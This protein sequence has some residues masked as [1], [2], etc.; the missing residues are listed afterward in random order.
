MNPLQ[1]PVRTLPGARPAGPHLPAATLRRHLDGAD[2][3]ATAH[4]AA[5]QL[6]LE[7]EA[8]LA[9]AQREAEAIHTQALHE[10]AEER[11]TLGQQ[12]RDQAVADSLQWLCEEQQLE[13]E[14][15]RQLAQ[16]W[17]SLT[18]NVLEELL[19]KNDQTEM[20]LHRLQRKVAELLP[21]GRLALQV[22]PAELDA[23]RR[24][25]AAAAAV[26][27]SADAALAAGQAVLD[28]GLVRIHLDL[29][30]YQR[31]LLEQLAGQPRRSVHAG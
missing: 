28:N 5:T 11:T 23:T 22:A 18:A 4:A 26:A 3:V 14:L 12:A 6:R 20:L 25:F 7:A 21:Q 31:W 16:R 8:V 30:A 29:P 24:A 19:T 13:Q 10:A 9:Q 15:A 17:R 27:V 1:L 2:V